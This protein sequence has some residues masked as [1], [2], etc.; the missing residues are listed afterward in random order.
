MRPTRYQL[1]YSRLN[2][3]PH[4]RDYTAL[5]ARGMPPPKKKSTGANPALAVHA[6]RRTGSKSSTSHGKPLLVACQLVPASGGHKAKVEKLGID[7]S[8][9]RML[10]ERSTI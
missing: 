4:L 1:R 5:E 6:Q 8:A 7:P 2:S 10:S 9:S 3:S